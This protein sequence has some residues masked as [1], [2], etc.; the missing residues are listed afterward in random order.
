VFEKS[1]AHAEL[2]NVAAAAGVIR[3]AVGRPKVKRER[4]ITEIVER[5]RVFRRRE[6]IISD[7]LLP[8]R[9]GFYFFM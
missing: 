5:E 2:P 4:K 7:P 3:P 1:D 9:R 8:R 6:G